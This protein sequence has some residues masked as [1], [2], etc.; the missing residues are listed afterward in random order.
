MSLARRRISQQLAENWNVYRKAPAARRALELSAESQS[1]SQKTRTAHKILQR[2]AESAD[3]S[4]KIPAG[5]PK[6]PARGR[7]FGEPKESSV[8]RARILSADPRFCGRWKDL[9]SRR[10][11]PSATQTPW[12]L[13]FPVTL[14][15]SFQPR[16]ASR[17]TQLRLPA[18][19]GENPPSPAP[20]GPRSPRYPSRDSAT[21]RRWL[22][23]WSLPRSSSSHPG[24]PWLR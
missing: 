22:L 21:P 11:F 19:P 16:P 24:L 1:G 8:R 23:P 13:D 15:S 6:V 14:P 3:A 10:A 18:R 20:V 7:V 17:Q 2:A 9:L 4:P 5:R 12:T